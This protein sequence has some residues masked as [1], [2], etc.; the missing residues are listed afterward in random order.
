MKWLP[1]NCRDDASGI[2][3]EVVVPVPVR[4]CRF[5]RICKDRWSAMA[6]QPSTLERRQKP[7]FFDFGRP[8]SAAY[9]LVAISLREMSS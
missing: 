4:S 5:F 1:E 8:G 3:S 2:S 7:A 6:E 9:P